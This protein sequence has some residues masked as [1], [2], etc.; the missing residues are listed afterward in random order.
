M[1]RCEPR[2][3]DTDTQ[4]PLI[5]R[6]RGLAAS[7][8]ITALETRYVEEVSNT[9]LQDN[10]TITFSSSASLVSSHLVLQRTMV[11]LLQGSQDSKDRK[12]ASHKPSTIC[13]DNKG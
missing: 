9:I 11:K 4:F 5:N 2:V 1:T 3:R 10:L 6:G 8:N 7:L 13:M 12:S